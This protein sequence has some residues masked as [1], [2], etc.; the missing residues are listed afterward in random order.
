MPY[1]I[2]MK[3]LETMTSADSLDFRN[4]FGMYVG[5]MYVV[6]SGHVYKYGRDNLKKSTFQLFQL[7]SQEN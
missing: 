4:Y 6:A 1:L 5:Y 7:F 2:R 3:T